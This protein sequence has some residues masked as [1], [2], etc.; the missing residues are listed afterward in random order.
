[1]TKIQMKNMMMTKRKIW[2]LKKIIKLKSRYVVLLFTWKKLIMRKTHICLFRK[3]VDLQEGR[4]W[5]YIWYKKKWEEYQKEPI[6]TLW[7]DVYQETCVPHT[8][9]TPS[10]PTLAWWMKIWGR[11]NR[12]LIKQTYHDFYSSISSQQHCESQRLQ[13]IKLKSNISYPRK[14]CSTYF[15]NI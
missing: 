6:K 5:T 12:D 4:I 3:Q 9:T 13:I 7:H 8:F 15:Y 11:P 10:K 1:M 2:I 14:M